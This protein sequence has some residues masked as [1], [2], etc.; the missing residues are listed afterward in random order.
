MIVVDLIDHQCWSHTDNLAAM[1]PSMFIQSNPN[2]FNC[3]ELK[4][5]S[6]NETAS[7][8]PILSFYY[9]RFRSTHEMH[10]AHQSAL[11]VSVRF[12]DG[13]RHNK[14]TYNHKHQSC[15]QNLFN[16]SPF[17]N[18][19]L[20]LLNDVIICDWYRV[21]AHHRNHTLYRCC[22]GTTFRRLS[23]IRRYHINP[24]MGKHL[25]VYGNLIGESCNDTC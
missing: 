23:D 13:T 22:P 7:V 12:H 8:N 18:A 21:F 2:K 16:P 20:S 5:Q 17:S 15:W 10:A 6:I 1:F 9:R 25:D 4:A 19:L 11:H 14:T 24:A 3:R